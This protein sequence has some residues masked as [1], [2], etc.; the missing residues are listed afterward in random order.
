MEQRFQSRVWIAHRLQ[1]A[2]AANEELLHAHRCRPRTNHGQ[3]LHHV[4]ELSRPH[5]N[6]QVAHGRRF[7]LV[8]A[9]RIAA[10]EQRDGP[11]VGGRIRRA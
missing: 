6:Q 7:E 2:P 3:R 8:D 1:P 10:L 5:L 11:F 4:H 9:Q